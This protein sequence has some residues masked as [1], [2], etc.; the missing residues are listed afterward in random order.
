[1]HVIERGIYMAGSQVFYEPFPLL[2]DLMFYA[3]CIAAIIYFIRSI[4]IK[5][6]SKKR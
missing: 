6:K 3:M 4:I 2:F 5:I 1:M